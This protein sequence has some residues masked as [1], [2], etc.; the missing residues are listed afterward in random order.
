M[1][2]SIELSRNKKIEYYHQ[3]TGETYKD[4]RSKLKAYNWDLELA[5][6]IYNLPL[7]LDSFNQ[8]LESFVKTLE[9]F[10]IAATEAT[11]AAGAAF[12]KTFSEVLYDD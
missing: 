8:S 4:C 6:N 3:A 12:V 11:V 5:L 9:R 7:A 1:S 10:V 2:K